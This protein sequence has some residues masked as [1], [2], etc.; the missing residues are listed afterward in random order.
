MSSC[1]WPRCPSASRRGTGRD[2]AS[3][4]DQGLPVANRVRGGWSSRIV[5]TSCSELETETAA[6]DSGCC[7]GCCADWGKPRHESAPEA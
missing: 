7:G 1:C 5:A 3:G 6:V 2:G 4:K